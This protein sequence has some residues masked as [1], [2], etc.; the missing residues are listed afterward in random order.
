MRVK[1]GSMV[2]F[3]PLSVCSWSRFYLESLCRFVCAKIKMRTNLRVMVFT[4]PSLL[5][6]SFER[7]GTNGS[8]MM[9]IKIMSKTNNECGWP[10]MELCCCLENKV[11]YCSQRPEQLS[12]CNLLKQFPRSL[13][14]QY[15]CSLGMDRAVEESQENGIISFNTV[16]ML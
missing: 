15:W 5:K 13:W 7:R 3:S 16:I 1:Q 11:R 6:F 12:W 14:K 4:L 9:R 2:T 8:I 10:E